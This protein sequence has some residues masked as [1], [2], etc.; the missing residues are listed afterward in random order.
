MMMMMIG[1]LGERTDLVPESKERRVCGSSVYV[2]VR[3]EY[4]R[5]GFEKA[6]EVGDPENHR[7]CS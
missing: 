7:P 5:F 6:C 1:G 4:L 2:C 3:R